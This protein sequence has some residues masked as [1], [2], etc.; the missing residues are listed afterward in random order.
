MNNVLH[1]ILPQDFEPERTYLIRLILSDFLGIH[2]EIERNN[3]PD[4]KLILPNG[5]QLIIQDHFFSRFPN[6]SD[7][8]LDKNIPIPPQSKINFP[9]DETGSIVLFGTTDLIRTS[10]SSHKSIQWGNDI[11]AASFF[12]LTRWEE[13]AYQGEKDTF[14]RFP[15]EKNIAVRYDF[16]KRAIVNEYVNALQSLLKELGFNLPDSNRE[17]SVFVE[18]DV[19]YFERYPDFPTYLKTSFGDLLKRRDLGLSINSFRQ[20]YQKLFANAPD[21]F[22]TFDYLMD[23]SE[24]IGAK[25]QFYFLPGR[26]IKGDEYELFSR[27]VRSKIDHILERGH[28]V[29][30]H[31]GFNTAFD[32]SLLE[33]EFQRMKRVHPELQ[34]SRQHFLQLNLPYI[35][36]NLDQNGIR[37]DTSLG[38][39]DRNGFRN[40]CCYNYPYF[41]IIQRK[42][43]DLNVSSFALMDTVFLKNQYTVEQVKNE[44]KSLALQV[45][46]FNGDFRFLWHNSNLKLKEWADLAKYYHEYLRSIYE[47]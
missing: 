45:R 6:D 18:H 33:I 32:S 4:W 42:Q 22:D 27:K 46:H 17:F 24:V 1:I 11:F 8:Y 14:R 30:M 2:C 25:S 35:Y 43:L 31:P 37:L 26:G 20:G 16:Y 40:G 7:I 5:N 10:N 34:T 3:I 19:D 36:R 29:A 21:P 15:E 39:K 13:I 23:E 44:F 9:Q 41:D 38:F 12:M 28:F 47:S